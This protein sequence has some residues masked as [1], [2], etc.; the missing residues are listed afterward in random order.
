MFD[1]YQEDIYNC[2][3]DLG[4]LICDR[5]MEDKATKKMG[6]ELTPRRGGVL[7]QEVECDHGLRLTL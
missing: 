1:L 4:D 7:L 2:R 6:Q 5:Y 3:G